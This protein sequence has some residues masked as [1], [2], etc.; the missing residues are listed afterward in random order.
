NFGW[1]Y[2][3]VERYLYSVGPEKGFSLGANFNVSDPAIASDFSG[4]S[5][6]VNFATYVQMPWLQHHTIGLHA[7][8]G[9]SGGNLGGHGLFYV[10][11]FLDLPLVDTVRN[12]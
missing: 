3:N 8:G 2:S 4:Y 12:T 10:G 5:A 11:G 6:S 9:T 7:G 1:S